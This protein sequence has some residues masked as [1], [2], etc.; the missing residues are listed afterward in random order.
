MSDERSNKMQTIG[1]IIGKDRLKEKVIAE[2]K[3]E[4]CGENVTEIEA[5]IPF[6]PTKGQT[7]TYKR[8]C[9]CREIQMAKEILETSERLKIENKRKRLVNFFKEHSLINRTLKEATFSNY[10]P[11]SKELEVAKQKMIEYVADFDKEDSPSVLL[12][13]SYGTGKSHLSVATTKLLIKKD[14]SCVFISFPKLLRKI[15]DTYNKDSEITE[16]QLMDILE[17]V[18]LLVLDDIGAEKFVAGKDGEV[19]WKEEILFSILDGRAGKPTI[20]TSNLD[21]KSLMK[22][23]NERNFSRLMQDTE[24]IKM[25]GEDYRRREF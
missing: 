10:E 7:H 22:N 9:K 6:G 11:T 5:I 25:N 14:F 24:V 1:A 4:G 17:S 2:Y 23:I 21:S 18:D 8:N 12:L 16:D 15:R 13:G 19:S 3:C 20:Y